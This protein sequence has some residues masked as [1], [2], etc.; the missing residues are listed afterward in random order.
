MK[1]A[2]QTISQSGD[3]SRYHRRPR[4]HEEGKGAK[5][6]EKASPEGEKQPCHANYLH[7]CATTCKPQLRQTSAPI[8]SSQILSSR[9]PPKQETPPARW[10]SS[11]AVASASATAKRDEWRNHQRRKYGS[12]SRQAVVGANHGGHIRQGNDIFELEDDELIRA[13]PA[14]CSFLTPRPPAR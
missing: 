11:K 10:A 6:H 14:P 9:K 1:E 13:W 2:G 7:H 8:L 5:P 4:S 3:Q 12:Q